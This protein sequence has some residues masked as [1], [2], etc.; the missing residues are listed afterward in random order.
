MSSSCLHVAHALIESDDRSGAIEHLQAAFVQIPVDTLDPEI[1]GLLAD[2]LL[3]A[4]RPA[5]AARCYEAALSLDSGRLAWRRGLIVCLS[6]LGRAQEG[7]DMCEAL[8]SA[9]PDDPQGRRFM[10]VFLSRL[11]R[12]EAALLHARE[13]SF[14]APRDLGAL[15]DAAAVMA[16]AGEGLAGAEILDRALRQASPR[17][18]ERPAAWLALAKNWISL[19]EPLKA[20][21]ALTRSLEENPDDP[22]GAGDVLLQISSTLDAPVYD[23]PAAFVRGLFDRYADRFDDHLLQKLRYDAPSALAQL[24]LD[25]GLQADP[26]R[27][28]VD[29][30]CGTGL[31]GAAIRRLTGWLGGFDLSPRML[32]KA[33]GRRIYDALWTGEWN[34]TL[35]AR[36][37][38]F[39]LIAAGDVLV[40]MG[41]L[42]PAFAAAATAL[43]AGG[44]FAFTCE[45]AQ[46]GRGFYLHQGRRF[47]H[48]E[49][50]L[51]E[52]A[53]GAGLSCLR[54]AP[55]SARMDSGMPA[56]GFLALFCK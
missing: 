33:R 47:A 23:L 44:L 52:A 48:S 9:R 28:A 4:D 45:R 46:D 18:P 6:R 53:Q 16:M 39:D 25:H 7:V 43:R 22:S 38:A 5:E 29:A 37:A 21:D 32:D 40:Y 1:P 31:V 41:D 19:G 49:G 8:L 35:N 13:V 20:S 24:L 34:E 56:P 30:G 17:D 2:L 50:H 11:G 15:A 12:L 27:R 55:H 26:E 51:L 54:L 36:P 3:E 14:L 42:R 10:A